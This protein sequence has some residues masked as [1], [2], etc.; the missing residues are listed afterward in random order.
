MREGHRSQMA[1]GGTPKQWRGLTEEGWPQSHWAQYIAAD[2]T[3]YAI[4]SM[5]ETTTIL[6]LLWR[7]VNRKR[8]SLNKRNPGFRHPMPR[9]NSA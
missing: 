7:C 8:T 4:Y 5:I 6:D 3:Y 2:T 9:T 1:K